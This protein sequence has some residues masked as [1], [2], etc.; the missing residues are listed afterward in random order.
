MKE[1][2][3]RIYLDSDKLKLILTEHKDEI[4]KTPKAGIEKII[5]AVAFWIPMALA[6]FS[7]WQTIGTFV[8]IILILFGIA[9]MFYGVYEV[10]K[11]RR[12]P[13][14]KDSLYSEIEE[15]N[16]IK[17][18][19]H[20]IVLVK[21]TFQSNANRFLVYY[22]ARWNCKLFLNYATI[23]SDISEDKGNIAKHLQMELKLP[24]G[25]LEGAFAFEKVHE[26][27]SVSAKENRCYRHRF[28]Q[29]CIKEFAENIT[30]DSFEIDG[31]KFYW[32]SIA[33]MEND[34]RIMEAN[35]DIVG[36]VKKKSF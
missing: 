26:K 4:G 35:S 30:K 12:V 2:R 32:M 18:H 22:D 6:D 25:S 3:G 15:A 16:L 10:I 11:A 36:M 14:D 28:Y 33:E 8:Q 31:K 17:E 23:T 5:T 7:K 9:L 27:Y 20:S 1:N 34:K 21:D 19:P 13:F 29:F 24:E